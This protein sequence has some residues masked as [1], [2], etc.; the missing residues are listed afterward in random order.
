MSHGHYLQVSK[1][2]LHACSGLA[3]YKLLH[4]KVSSSCRLPATLTLWQHEP[5][6]ILPWLLESECSACCQWYGDIKTSRL[7]DAEFKFLH[8]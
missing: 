7:R 3:A 8:S 5:K 1:V 2:V 6:M 4:F